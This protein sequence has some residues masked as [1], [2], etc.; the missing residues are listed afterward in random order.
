MT[1]GLDPKALLPCPFCGGAAEIDY[2]RGFRATSSGKLENA[3]AVYCLDCSA[4]MTLCRSDHREYDAEQLGD[5]LIENW[6]RRASLPAQA[7]GGGEVVKPLEWEEENT[8]IRSS[9]R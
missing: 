3:V 9:D 1:E 7:D 6:N 8:F 2:S 5:M 4:D